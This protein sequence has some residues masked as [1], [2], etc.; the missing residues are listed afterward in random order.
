MRAPMSHDDLAVVC[1]S[2]DRPPAEEFPMKDG[3]F[4]A[5]MLA[6]LLFQ[7]A[8]SAASFAAAHSAHGQ[9]SKLIQGTAVGG[10]ASYS[11][12]AATA[13]YCMTPCI[14]TQALWV[15]PLADVQIG[16]SSSPNFTVTSSP[17]FDGVW[18]IVARDAAGGVLGQQYFGTV[19]PQA[20]V[21][22][23]FT[24]VG[25]TSVQACIGEETVLSVRHVQAHASYQWYRDGV[26]IDG[27]VG[28]TLSFEVEPSHSGA[29]FTCIAT[30]GCGSST[31]GPFQISTSAGAASVEVDW[32]SCVERDTEQFSGSYWSCSLYESTVT[33]EG[34]CRALWTTLNPSSLSVV[35][36]S[37]SGVGSRTSSTRF[38]I[39][40]PATLTFTSSRPVFSCAVATNLYF[41][42]SAT[43]SG[44]VQANLVPT[45]TGGS[46][47]VE[48]VPGTYTVNA[49]INGGTHSCPWTCSGCGPT[50]LTICWGCN[51][52]GRMNLSLTVDA[53]P[54]DVPGLHPTI[55]SAIDAAPRGAA[56]T[57]YVAPGTYNESFSLNGKNVV[58]CGA[59]DGTTILSGTGLTT[60]IAN[61]NGEPATAGLENLVFRNGTAG[62]AI[63]PPTYN[64]KGGGAVFGRDSS[65]FIRNCVFEDCAADLGAGVYLLRGNINVEGCTF[66]SNDATTDA[67]GM[68]AYAASGTVRDSTFTGNRCALTYEGSG[69]AFKAVG[70]RA[71]GTDVT[72]EGCTVSGNT[73]PGAGAAVEYYENAEVLAG[74]LRVVD[75]NIVNN[76]VDGGTP[77]DAAGLRVLGSQAACVLSD[78]T[79]ICGNTPRNVEGPYLAEGEWTVC[80][81]LAD[82]TN[83][84][85]VSAAD[86][87]LLLTWWS[88]ASPSGVGDVN[89]DGVVNATDLSLMLVE[90]GACKN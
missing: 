89:H 82:F 62:Q 81:C 21:G 68:M 45:N 88:V 36:E 3:M 2:R 38:R 66:T 60:S 83:D 73:V 33:R 48:L 50:C 72:L 20:A 28:A 26:P 51:Y 9:C 67:G 61:L 40:T 34:S 55:Q 69:S 49:G 35:L 42:S 47:T 57:I 41:N 4:R 77:N 44:P 12:S 46:G 32:V 14:G 1:A 80:D 19:G 58:V 24:G 43:L 10:A 22:R 85:Y 78:G 15:H 79:T 75:T 59:P 6:R 11:L 29:L 84:G 64:F 86:L 17:D 8:A 39:E 53:Q 54:F 63:N 71:A 37:G 65:A 74:T 25:S 13:R 76:L 30:N 5:S 23:P 90:W 56:K 27:A 18:K 7:S 87:S 70:I 31:A 52:W 16:T